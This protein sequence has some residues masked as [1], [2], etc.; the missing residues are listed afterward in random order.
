MTQQQR[1]DIQR[2]R[3]RFSRLHAKTDFSSLLPIH[4]LLFF[5]RRITVSVVPVVP[6]AQYHEGSMG[7]VAK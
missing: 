1:R 4:L 2:K 3:C 6:S 5:S 7:V